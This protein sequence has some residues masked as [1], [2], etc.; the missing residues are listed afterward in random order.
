MSA[1]SAPVV[2][3]LLRRHGRTHARELG[4]ELA[5]ATPSPLFRW[6]CAALLLSARIGSRT[7]LAAAAALAREGWRTPRSMLEAGWRARVQ[8]LDRAGYAR[9]DESTS[10]MLGESCALLLDRY[11]GD[12]RRLREAAGRAPARERALLM[13]LK[14]IGEV[15][16]DIFFRELQSS[17]T[18]HYPFAD[19]KALDVASRLGLGEDARAL[20]GL[21]AQRDFPRLVV[22]LVRCGLACDAG[23]ILEMAHGLEVAHG[24]TGDGP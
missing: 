2:R 17:W 24:K 1:A 16:A 6:M 5:R 14:G 13:E 19:P 18:E 12:L 4:I 15:G 8:V 7:A 10:R 22:A 3:A 21:V 23:V 9:Y 20:A 11:G